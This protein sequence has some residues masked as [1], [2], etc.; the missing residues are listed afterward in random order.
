[1][2]ALRGETDEFLSAES[3]CLAALQHGVR[4][5][6]YLLKIES[7]GGISA[8]SRRGRLSSVPKSSLVGLNSGICRRKPKLSTQDSPCPVFKVL[9][10]AFGGV[11][12][13]L[14]LDQHYVDALLVHQCG[15][16]GECKSDGL[17][18]SLLPE[19]R[20]AR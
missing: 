5:S 4:C 6:E 14:Q 20:F 12:W 15:F 2:A 19:Q 18:T 17:K 7:A 10:G 8:S 11:V 9:I 3:F 1:M 13:S 16:Y